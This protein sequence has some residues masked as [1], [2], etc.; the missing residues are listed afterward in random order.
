MT[1][2]RDDDHVN[3]SARDIQ[4]LAAITENDDDVSITQGDNEKTSKGI[5]AFA[6]ITAFAE[7]NNVLTPLPDTSLQC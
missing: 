3:M 6:A 7:I 4:D 5:F 2:T 1:T